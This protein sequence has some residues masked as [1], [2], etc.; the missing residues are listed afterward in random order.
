M[1]DEK[2]LPSS[3]KR[4]SQFNDNNATSATGDN[5]NSNDDDRHTQSTSDGI[6]SQCMPHVK[7]AMSLS[8][9]FRTPIKQL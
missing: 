8:S 3:L 4:K 9:E 6:P 2:H 5:V 1:S 7:D